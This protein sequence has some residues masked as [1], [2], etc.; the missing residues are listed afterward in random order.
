MRMNLKMKTLAAAVI[1]TAAVSTANAN[2]LLFPYFTTV[3][4]AQSV[5]SL[6]SNVTTPVHYVYNYGSSCTHFD[7]FGAL[8]ANDV[9]QHS[10]M[11]PAAGGFGMAVAGDGSTPF[12]MPLATD[13]FLV[14]TNTVGAATNA[15]RGEMVIADAATG[16]M[17]AYTPVDNALDTSAA[18]N[19]GDF[20]AIVDS[21]FRMTFYPDVVAD[22]SWYA[23]VVGDMNAAI[24]AG[25]DWTGATTWTTAAA[26][27]DNDENAFSGVM[28]DTITCSGT[29][30]RDDLLNSAQAASINDGGLVLNTF[31]AY[32]AGATGVV[33]TKM[34]TVLPAVGAPFA[35][36]TFLTREVAN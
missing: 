27:Y 19:E 14:V 20:S 11:A 4:G 7:G 23:V 9:I 21:A 1:A 31:G 16:I 22:T 36:T 5:L 25:A 29:I 35:G 12:Y 33:L 28:S 32:A 10:I 30:D 2:S 18:G 8:T 6:T 13:G 3:N 26:A 17:T 34:Q 24:A 15:L